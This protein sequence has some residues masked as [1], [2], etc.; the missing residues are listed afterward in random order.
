MNRVL[1]PV[2]ILFTFYTFGLCLTIEEPTDVVAVRAAEPITVDGKL[3][4]S[5]WQHT[6]PVTDLHQSEPREGVAATEVSTI[7]LAYDDQALYVGATL[8]DSAPDSIVSRLGRR[9]SHVDADAFAVFIDPY[10]DH[11]SGYFFGMSVGGTRY[12]GVLYNDNHMDDTWDGVW[13]GRCRIEETGWTAE[14][15]IPFSQLRFKKSTDHVWG[16]NFYRKIH[17]KHEEDFLVFTPKAGSGFVS[18][19]VHLT[20]IH[21]IPAARHLELLPYV[22]SKGEFIPVDAEH[23]FR[24]GSD[25]SGSA[26]LDLKYGLGSNLT[27]DLTLNPDFGQVEVDPAVVNLSDVETF[28]R[29]KRPFFIEGESIFHFGKGGAREIWGFNWSNPRFFHSRRI[30]RRP[31]GDEPDHDYADIPDGTHILGAVKLTGKVG[32]GWN[33][34]TVQALT[35][36]ERGHFSLDGESFDQTLEPLTYYG[37]M[38]AQKEINNGYRGVGVIG[39]LTD[40]RLDESALKPQFN[41]RSGVIGMDGWTFLNK[42]Q[43]W[44]VSAWAGASQVQ[45]S[46]KRILDLQTGSTHY[47]QRPDAGHVSVDSAATSLSGYAGRIG[48]VKQKGNVIFNSAVG[49]ISPGFDINDLGY[50]RK[51][52]VI[53]MHVASGYQWTKPGRWTREVFL[54]G[55]VFQS[56]DFSGHTLW[57]GIFGLCWIQLPNYWGMQ[58]RFAYNP[59]SWDSRHTRGG[60]LT[61]QRAG[62][63]FGFEWY[64]DR[65]KPVVVELGSWGYHR[66]EDEWRVGAETEIEWKPR[67]NISL[68]LEPELRWNREIAQWVDS[69]S[70]PAATHT[71]GNRYVF[72]SMDQTE[73]S[74]SLRLNWTFS[75]NMSL[76]LYMQPLISHGDYH[77]FKELA[78]PKSYDYRD[79][80]PDEIE[81]SGDD[82]IVTPQGGKRFEF[83]DPDFHVKSLRGNAVFRWEYRPG[84]TLYFVWTQNKLDDNYYQTFNLSRSARRFWSGTSENIF[85]VKLTYWW[86]A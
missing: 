81:K 36:T 63:E 4:E 56:M 55:A 29:E 64:S 54:L 12:D 68:E 41:N 5:I 51:T 42:N 49:A 9:D 16:I 65:R 66:T 59:E 85:M 14:F 84:S 35:R 45:G 17:R 79:Y 76:Q 48:L 6:H 61:K 82:Y 18:R 71:Y 57:N 62:R 74:A 60:P 77:D 38:R 26:G 80:T 78:R 44:V 10:H 47:F 37:V 40:R 23:P 72:A 39:T 28:Y 30:G 15:R 43:S 20:G 69:F 1:L 32:Q 2:W 31:Q 67:A 86:N 11:R 13:E 21:D 27:L 24:D 8:T 50:L 58:Y 53:N 25:F 34:G 33:V 52:D 73:L 7:R 22:R 75:S 70:D 83:G 19:F 3:S 46:Q